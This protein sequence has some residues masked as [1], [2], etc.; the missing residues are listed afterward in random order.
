MMLLEIHIEVFCDDVVLE[1]EQNHCK[2]YFTQ[3][4]SVTY[5]YDEEN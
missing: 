5:S 1:L 3:S 4:N 2:Y